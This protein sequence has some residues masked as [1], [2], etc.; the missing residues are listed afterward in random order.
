MAGCVLNLIHLSATGV[1]EIAESTYLGVQILIYNV[2]LKTLTC[3]VH[4][5]VP[6]T[7]QYI[8]TTSRSHGGEVLF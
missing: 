2:H 4:L 6:H 1:A 8:H 3:S 7:C 5:S